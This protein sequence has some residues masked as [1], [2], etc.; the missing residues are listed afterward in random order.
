LLQEGNKAF[1]EA[2]KMRAWKQLDLDVEEMVNEEIYDHH[3]DTR[4]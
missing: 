2:D 1:F 3:V 4:Y